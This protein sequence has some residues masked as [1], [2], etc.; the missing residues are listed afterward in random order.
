M[1]QRYIPNDENSPSQFS[2][3][4]VI[5]A[6]LKIAIN[7]SILRFLKKFNME[8]NIKFVSSILLAKFKWNREHICDFN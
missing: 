2:L 8:L 4:C 1:T 6:K 3:F 5:N 7:H